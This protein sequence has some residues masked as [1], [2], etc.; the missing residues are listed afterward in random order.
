MTYLHVVQVNIVW[1]DGGDG[2]RVRYL[3]G[4]N[5]NGE[6]LGLSNWKLE[7]SNVVKTVLR[8]C[9]ISIAVASMT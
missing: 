5:D 4:R 6:F 7:M 1:V 8:F 2:T 3:C 9:S